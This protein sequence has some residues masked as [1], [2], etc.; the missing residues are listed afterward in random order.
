M[1]LTCLFSAHGSP[2]VTTATMLLA[3]T[4]PMPHSRLVV[5]AD[6]FGGV[7]AARFGL[8]DTPGLMSLAAETRGSV[9]FE[10][11]GRHVQ[12]LADGLRVLVAPPS[13]DQAK[14]VVCDLAGPL[15]AWAGS[16]D[17]SVFVD[18]GRLTAHP[19][20]QAL[21]AAADLVLAVCRPTVD[22]LRPVTALTRSVEAGGVPVRLVL[23][24]D[25]PYGPG[26]VE[27]S[28]GLDVA[29]VLAWD[30]D[31]A[32]AFNGVRG[33][34]RRW[35]RS[36]LLRSARSLAAGLAGEDSGVV[37]LGVVS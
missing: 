9:D 21:L 24:G 2:G 19:P 10:H 29:G 27:S 25:R 30:P 28:L 13:A 20:Q 33:R 18:C 16:D 4:W 35:D 8:A 5:E 36:P 31:A 1:T 23:V 14:A 7:V 11:V 34:V 15:S 3:S 37:R 6:V 12:E 32:D 22:Q 26:E 17:V